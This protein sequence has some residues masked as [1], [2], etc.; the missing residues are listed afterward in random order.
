MSLTEADEDDPDQRQVYRL[1][2]FATA[3][4]TPLAFAAIGLTALDN[5]VF[6][7]AAGLVSG[8]GSFVFVPWFVRLSTLSADEDASL[9]TLARRAPGNPATKLFGLG[10]DLGGIVMLTV[11]FSLGPNL[12][13]G[14]GA[15]LAFAL[16]VYLATAIG[17]SRLGATSP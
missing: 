4:G 13:V 14:L 15:G 12:P 5:V 6:G 17:F 10:L 8:V 3:V 2:Q 9:L 1:I 11:G 16:T 7:L